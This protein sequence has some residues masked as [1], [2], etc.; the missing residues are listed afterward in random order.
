[1]DAENIIVELMRLIFLRTQCFLNYTTK[2]IK[3]LHIV[4]IT[5]ID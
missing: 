5:K 1:M 2:G 4:D 3:V